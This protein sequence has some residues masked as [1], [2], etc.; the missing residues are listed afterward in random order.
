MDGSE[1]RRVLKCLYVVL[2]D[3]IRIELLNIEN[4]ATYFLGYTGFKKL[5]LTA[6]STSEFLRMV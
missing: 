6:T 3:S 1:T 4:F 2:N 5:Y